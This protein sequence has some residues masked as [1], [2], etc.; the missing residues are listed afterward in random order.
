MKKFLFYHLPIIL[1]SALIL[2]VSAMPNLRTPEVRFLA[3]DKVFHFIEYA[4]FAFL[5]YRSMLHLRSVP[6]AGQALV[7]SFVLLIAFAVI[8][9]WVQKYTPGRHA[10]VWDYL[11]DVVGGSVVLLLLWWRQRRI[12]AQTG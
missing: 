5:A 10:E 3:A 9:E 8:D 7:T 12:D 2:T 4:L 1:Y 6:R 11:T